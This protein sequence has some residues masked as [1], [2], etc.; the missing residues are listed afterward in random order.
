VGR[1]KDKWKGEEREKE[2]KEERHKRKEASGYV[3]NEGITE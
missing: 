1:Q 3:K 2:G